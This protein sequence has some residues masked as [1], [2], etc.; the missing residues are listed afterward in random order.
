MISFIFRMISYGVVDIKIVDDDKIVVNIVRFEK[1]YIIYKKVF[2]F[3]RV[4]LVREIDY[5][6]WLFNL[7]KFCL[8]IFI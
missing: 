7:D 6:C 2:K 5:L 4:I 3:F 1:I 8:C